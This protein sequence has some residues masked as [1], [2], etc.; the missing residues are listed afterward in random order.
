MFPAIASIAITIITTSITRIRTRIIHLL[1][2]VHTT[3]MI[4]FFLLLWPLLLLLLSL[5]FLLLLLLLLVLFLFFVN[6]ITITISRDSI[7]VI[8]SSSVGEKPKTVQ[9]NP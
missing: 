8:T 4:W 2:I 1:V 6:I 3:I 5:L 7:F 9:R